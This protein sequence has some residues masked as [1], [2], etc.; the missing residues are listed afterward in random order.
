MNRRN[1]FKAL[2]VAPVAAI[3]GA[4]ITSDIAAS[5]KAAQAWAEGVAHG[6]AISILWEEE[7]QRQAELQLEQIMA[8]MREEQA[9][10]EQEVAASVNRV[11]TR[12]LTDLT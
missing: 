10:K 2:A 5:N 9:A 4:A 8:H 7:R 12:Y 6:R 11:L 3:G 1:F